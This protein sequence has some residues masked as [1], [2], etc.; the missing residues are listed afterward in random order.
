VL[1]DQRLELDICP[2]F[3]IYSTRQS[4]QVRHLTQGL[5]HSP[6]FPGNRIRTGKY[7]ESKICHRDIPM[8]HRDSENMNN[9]SVFSVPLWLKYPG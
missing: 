8:R 1:L 6:F 2:G 9:V 4:S 3:P 5:Y 7:S